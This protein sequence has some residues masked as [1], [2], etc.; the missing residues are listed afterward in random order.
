MAAR[1]PR[2]AKT[3]EPGS[4]GLEPAAVKADDPPEAVTATLARVQS[5][6]GEVLASY[7][8]PLGGNWLVLAVLPLDQLVATPF[9]R[10]LSEAHAKRLERV[11]SE[12]GQF[13]DPV[14]AVPVPDTADVA[15]GTKAAFWT[16]NGNH[17]LSALQRIGAK[18]VTALISPEP[19]LAYR[20]LAL[21]TEKA[22]N[23]KERSLEAIRMARGLAALDP[24]RAESDF[25]LELEEGALVTL[26][27]AYEERAR[28]AG[29]AY[30]P[31]LRLS[32]PFLETGIG[33]ALEERAGFA[34]RLLA[35]DDRV[36]EIITQLKERGFD[37]PYLRNF[38]VSRIRPFRPRGK[39]A[40]EREGLFAHME[41][42]AAKFDLAKVREG[43]VA[44]AAG[45]AD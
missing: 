37:S 27:L 24:G 12:V 19:A 38:V 39:P 13:L 9:Q 18:S 31:A 30:G 22:H 29:G 40:P 25:A 7:R 11:I 42:K 33:D 23:L 21:N 17:R 20:I 2:R 3:A 32:D 1:K 4:A 16:P 14:V 35:I 15:K 44:K 10:D 45:A 43:Q 41:E 34:K 26:G 5:A 28:F 36:A 6:G 8:D